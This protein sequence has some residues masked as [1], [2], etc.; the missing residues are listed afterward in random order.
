MVSNVSINGWEDGCKKK[1]FKL[2][3]RDTRD[4][5][6]SFSTESFRV[7]G[8]GPGFFLTSRKR[9]E[10]FLPSFMEGCNGSARR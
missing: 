10:Y 3:F 9:S 5:A 6:A 8:I 2:L 4:S 7:A 1:V